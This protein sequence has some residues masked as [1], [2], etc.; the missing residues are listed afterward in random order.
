MKNKFLNG[1]L[2]GLAATFVIMAI[3]VTVFANKINENL[4]RE[5]TNVKTENTS[6]AKTE[7]TD[8]DVMEKIDRLEGLINKYYMEDV[9]KNTMAEG[10]YKGLLSSLKDPYSVYYTKDEYAAL[11]ESSSG[12][13]YGIGAT[14]SAD[15]KT[16]ILSI[17]KP[18]VGG[19]ANKAGILPGDVLYKVNGEEVTGK[20]ITEVV[21]KIKGEEGSKVTV[22]IIREGKSKPVD[23]TIV[24]KKVEVPTI[25]YQMLD[26]KIGYI[27]VSEFDEV[28]AEQFRAAV[29]DLEKQGEKGLVIDIRNNPGGLLDTVVDMLKRMLPSGMIVYTEDKYGNR[30]EYKSDGKEEFNKPLAVLINGNSASASEIF[31]G[32]IQDYKKGTL[33]GTTSFGKGIVQSILPLNDGT[34]IK[35]T[36]SKYY[37]PKGRNIHKIGITPDVTVELK[38]SLRQKVVIDKSEDNQL[39]KALQILNKQIKEK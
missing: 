28:T 27:A 15:A 18:F 14:V 10:I 39:Q 30:D 9:D 11:M 24:R 4:T 6:A 33:V 2:S 20:D 1:F 32:A 5:N 12:I 25:E 3:V 13:Y 35:V 16:G 26:N 19:P 37:T 34:A 7:V 8:Q 21:G 23:Y 38:E 17:V 29:D 31:A 36:V 22:S